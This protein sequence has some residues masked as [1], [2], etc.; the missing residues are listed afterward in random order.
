MRR[1]R[2]TR[3]RA[4]LALA[5]AAGGLF[6]GAPPARAELIELAWTPAGR[7]E[8][9]VAVAPGKFAEICGALAK[10]QSVQWSFRAGGVLDFNIHYHQGEDVRYPARADGVPR[11]EGTLVVDAA[12]DYCWMWTNKSGAPVDLEVRLNRR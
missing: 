1:T 8:R 12:R 10:G 6:A 2:E 5:A 7:F 4:A 9:Q 11:S 3:W